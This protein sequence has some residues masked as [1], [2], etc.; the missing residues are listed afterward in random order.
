MNNYKTD[1]QWFLGILKKEALVNKIK[2]IKI[3]ITDID[4]SLT[5][6][7]LMLADSQYSKDTLYSSFIGK[8]FSTQD[9]FI[10]DK[11]IKHNLLLI[12]FLTG[13]TDEA[14]KIRAKMLG[15]PKDLCFT[16]I[17]QKKIDKVI[18]IQKNKDISKEETLYFGD[19]FL[20]YE[21]TNATAIMASPQNAPFYLQD[22]ADIII[23][24]DGGNNSFRLLL[25]LVLYIQ[26][27]HFAQ[28]F[29]TNSL[30]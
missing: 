3:I 19:D 8:S 11:I 14:T 20:D 16:G 5:N 26:N 17:S 24:R 15:I 30:V 4:G 12:A 2:N 28:S 27:K 22:K 18:S 7:N 1:K 23:P 25:D 13:R 21:T 10:I 29:I 6:G 9:G